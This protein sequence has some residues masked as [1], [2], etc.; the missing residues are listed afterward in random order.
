MTIVTRFA[1]SPTGGLH[2]GSGRTALFNYLFAKRYNGKFLLRIED[3]DQARSK[4]EFEDIIIESMHWL[5][6]HQDD[7]I[8]Y[9]LA[10]AERHK[11]IAH[12]LVEIGK[13]Y[14]CYESQEEIAKLREEAIG[15]GEHFLFKSPWRDG[16]KPGPEGVKPVIR[17]KAP[18]ED[19][20]VLQDLVQG[21]VVVQ[22]DH[23][24]DMILLRSDGTPTYMLA[25]VVDDHDMK[26]THVIRGD[27]HLNNTFRQL[28]IYKAM[29]W[30]IPKFAH[31]PLIHGSDGAKLSK[32]HGALSVLEYKEMGILPEAL[33]NYLLRLGWSHG[34][35]EIISMEQAIEWF[36]IENI[37]RAAA[38]FDMQKLLNLNAHYIKE[39]SN[40]RLITLIEENVGNI[41]PKYK[42][43]LLKGLDS[44]KVRAK[45]LIDL[46]DTSKF[47][48]TDDI[49]ITSEA[50]NKFDD[51]KA[52]LL[53]QIYELLNN[54][55]NWEL[56]NIQVKVNE[57][58]EA[59][60]LK[61]GQFGEVVRIAVTGSTNSPSVFE[62]ITIL[63]KEEALRRI[64][65]LLD[66]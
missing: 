29:G 10:R 56:T 37:G 22:N 5:G 18:R 61:M 33:N 21:E 39:S 20:T 62:I 26:V 4:K 41:E 9:Q 64:K 55:V 30:D 27:D 45:T 46:T 38:K 25:V 34:N 65:N 12:K 58:L 14:F 6:L 19:Q 23:L 49:I 8:Y 3:T 42:E 50:L 13:A 32:R 52:S 40:E 60:S 51:S 54:I 59:N 47:Y 24:D 15:K 43:R 7:E 2:I 1:P 57:F 11:E 35:D 36:N 44:L 28:L 17:I 53:K 16:N 66:K 31:I 63:G 48:L